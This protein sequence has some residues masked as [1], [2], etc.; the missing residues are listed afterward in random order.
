MK[1]SEKSVILTS[2]SIQEKENMKNTYETLKEIMISCGKL[3]KLVSVSTGEV[4]EMKEI[5]RVLGIL[6]GLLDSNA[7]ALQ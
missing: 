4:I 2:L 5:P 1:C 7:W 6:S 3:N